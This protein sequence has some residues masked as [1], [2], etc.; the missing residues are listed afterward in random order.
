MDATQRVI[1]TPSDPGFYEI[2]ARRYPPGWEDVRDKH[3]GEFVFVCRAGS[4]LMEP[5][6]M[7]EFDEYFGGG[8]YDDRMAEIEDD[9]DDDELTEGWLIF[10]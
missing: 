9:E 6:G 7:D 8:E 1:M 4:P 2:L 3:H 5:V 10:E